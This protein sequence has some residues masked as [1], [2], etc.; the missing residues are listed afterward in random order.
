MLSLPRVAGR[1]GSAARRQARA[2]PRALRDDRLAA[3]RRRSRA[4]SRSRRSISP[5]ERGDG[6]RCGCRSV[7]APGELRRRAT[8]ASACRR[9]S[10]ST[11]QPGQRVVVRAPSGDHPRHPRRRTAVDGTYPVPRRSRSAGSIFIAVRPVTF[12]VTN[13]RRAVRAGL[14]AW[15]HRRA[16]ASRRR[17]GVRDAARLT[18]RR[19]LLDPARGRAEP[20]RQPGREARAAPAASRRA[21]S[22][23]GCVRTGPFL[24]KK[25]RLPAI[26]AIAHRE[27]A[28]HPT[29]DR[30]G[31]S[32]GCARSAPGRTLEARHRAVAHPLLEE[33][34]AVPRPQ[35]LPVV[36]PRRRALARRAARARAGRRRCR[37]R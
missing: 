23:T 28:V 20:I 13:V 33:A 36:E 29:R 24:A 7:Q 16:H 31:R 26:F 27:V 19:A 21:P 25:R 15:L 9:R 18:A 35:P 12:R 22:R 30:R 2:V 4:G 10:C 32:R 5:A 6:R 34:P 3:R 11:S 37:G 14:R 17:E 8:C 1:E